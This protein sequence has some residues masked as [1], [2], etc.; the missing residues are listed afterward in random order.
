MVKIE[1]YSA[2]FTFLA[3]CVILCFLLGLPSSCLAQ[4]S[5]LEII[6]NESDI[7]KVYNAIGNVEWSAANLELISEIWR[8]GLDEFSAVERNERD[9]DIIMLSIANVLMQAIRHCKV[10]GINLSDVHDFVLSRIRSE[11]LSIRGRATILLGLAGYNSDIPFLLSVV[12]EEEMGYA[13]EAALSI[14]FI[15]TDESLA[16]LRQELKDVRRPSLK[17][18]LKDL[19]KDYGTYPIREFS[20]SCES[21]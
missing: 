1:R 16:A 18:F 14:R 6:R 5:V 4:Q 19:L 21:K 3:G 20:E 10:R 2:S 15:H 12:R 13:E 8:N 9:S 17:R 7:D 11:D